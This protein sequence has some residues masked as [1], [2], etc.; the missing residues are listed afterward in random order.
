M[1][2]I[3][4]SL[5]LGGVT[6]ALAQA[7]TLPPPPLPVQQLKVEVIKSYPHDPQAFT[8]GLLLYGQSLFESTG[9]EGRSTLRE[10]D[11]ESGRVLRKI[12]VPLPYFAEGLALAGDRL[13]QLT[14]QHGTAFI[15]DAFSFSER[16]RVSYGGEGWGLTYDGQHL[17]M[18]DGSDEL[19]V[20]DPNSFREERR[21][22]VSVDG[23][24]LRRLNELE[25]VDH[26]IYANI[27]T[28]PTIAVIDE[29]TGRVAAMI[30]ASGLL[31]PEESANADVLNGIAYDPKSGEFLITGKLWPKLFR[32]RFVPR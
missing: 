19:S 29:S 18:S 14:W 6:V 31:R 9:L 17:I 16:T 8:Q 15:Y 23:K 4:L 11:L 2:R 28:K 21:I 10:V 7:P 5:V 22:K 12:D 3:L 1:F 13:F 32:V 20:R 30:D 25:W 26:R 27:W 24:P